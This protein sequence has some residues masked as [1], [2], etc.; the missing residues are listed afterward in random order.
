MYVA[1]GWRVAPT[2]G[3]GK[4]TQQIPVGDQYKSIM[5]VI[6]C[7]FLRP[8]MEMVCRDSGGGEVKSLYPQRVNRANHFA[9]S[10]APTCGTH[11][12]FAKSGDPTCG[13]HN[14]FA[15]SGDPTCGTHNHFAKSADPTCGMLNHFAKS[16]APTCGMLNHFAK[17]GAPTCGML[18][19]FAKNAVPKCGM[20]NRFAKSA[21]PTCGMPNRFAKN[22]V[23]K[24]EYVS[25]AAPASRMRIAHRRACEAYRRYAD[26]RAPKNM[27][28]YIY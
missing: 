6:K 12:H 21:V 16:G 26:S 22:A 10:G 11:N 27:L 13:T 8:F 20:P 1:P 17:S 28:I 19:H 7:P 9:K 18:N 2:G 5:I 23:P 24:H 14:H 25:I 15:K 4:S 3:S